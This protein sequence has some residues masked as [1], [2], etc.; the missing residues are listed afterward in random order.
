MN[1]AKQLSRCHV[2]SESVQ[3]VKI[4]LRQRLTSSRVYDLKKGHCLSSGL[5]IILGF[6]Y[7]GVLHNVTKVWSPTYEQRLILIFRFAAGAVLGEGQEGHAP[8]P[9][10]RG[11]AHNCP[12]SE[13]WWM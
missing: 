9:P 7:S 13:I 4:I 2:R 11:L 3:W 5:N 1:T 6:Y 12:S 10:V 8:L